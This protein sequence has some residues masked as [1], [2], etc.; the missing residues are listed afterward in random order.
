MGAVAPRPPRRR[1]NLERKRPLKTNLSQNCANGSKA[2][3]WPGPVRSDRRSLRQSL[4]SAQAPYPKPYSSGEP[5][6]PFVYAVGKDNSLFPVDIAAY[7]KHNKSTQHWAAYSVGA[8]APRPP[9]RRKISSAS[10]LLNNLER[11]RPLKQSRARA[12]S[13]T[14]SSASDI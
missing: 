2:E 11:E 10:D 8:V 1:K 14:I 9:R 4:I 12:T 13:Q 5:A 7:R 6:L 3:P